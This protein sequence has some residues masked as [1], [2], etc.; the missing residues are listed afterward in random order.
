MRCFYSSD[1]DLDLP[2]NHPFPKDKFSASREMLLQHGVLK[3]E[4]IIDVKQT[5]LHVLKRVHDGSYLSKIY[6]GALDRKEQIAL[7]LPVSAKLFARC[8]TEAEATRQ[9]CHAAL[10]EG[11]AVCLAG[12]THHAFKGRGE[13]FCVFNDVAIAIR[14]LQEKQPGIKIMV[15]DTDAAQGNG[16]NSLLKDDPRVFTYSIHVGHTPGTLNKVDGNMDVETVRFVEG[17]MYLKQLFN[18]LA[19]ALDVFNPDLVIWV[20]GADN[21]SNDLLGNM[22]LTV[23]DMQRR[24]DVIIRAFIKNR[25]PLAILYGGGYNRQPDLTAKLHR[26]TVASAKKIA[27]EFGKG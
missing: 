21:H 24:D 18:T 19:S 15:V 3:P 20:A 6:H 27:K 17:D 2:T 11:V 23:A 4:E 25:I 10:A 26:N 22:M 14:D 1:L 16:T 13:A 5:D 7:G 8:A 9:T 12:G